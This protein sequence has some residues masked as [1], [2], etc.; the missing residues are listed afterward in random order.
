[1]WSVHKIFAGSGINPVEECQ[2]LSR[3]DA[4]KNTAT[5]AGHVG[6]R[7]PDR[8]S[9]GAE[10]SEGACAKPEDGQKRTGGASASF[11]L[12]RS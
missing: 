2:V 4:V 10:S 12:R 3:S 5:A 6:G 7:E 9:A 1:L 11:D 8:I